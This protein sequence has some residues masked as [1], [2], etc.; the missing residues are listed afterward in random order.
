MART[1]KIS[2][3]IDFHAHI[4]MPEVQAWIRA[5]AKG[6]RKPRP[7][8]SP[9]SA[10]FQK[11]QDKVVQ[12]RS[13]DMRA[14]IRDMD[15]VG[16]DIQV[17]SAHLTHFCYW[18]PARKGLEVARMFND[19]A[20]EIVAAHPSRFVAL[21][22]VPLQ[23]PKLAVRELDRAIG[24]GARGVQISSRTEEK[25][26]GDPAHEPFWEAAEAS[27]LPVYIHPHGFTNTERM[28]EYFLWNSIAQPLEEA[29][30]M[31]SIIYSGLLDRYPRLKIV[32]AHGG[33]FLPYYAGR[34]DRA[35]DV[36][37]ETRANINRKPSAYMRK[38]YYDTCVYNADMVQFLAGKVGVG[39]IV[40]GSDY[41]VFLKEPDPVAFVQKVRGLKAADRRRITGGTAARLLKL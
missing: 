10:A 25:E 36:R 39:Q 18:A 23:A 41:P 40:M 31:S 2:K 5:N 27:G 14:R 37:T 20:A 15:K 11:R 26:L 1:P 33:G 21:A 7:R 4:N 19:R 8:V 32:M 3:V 30:A 28:G 17:I 22:A 24:L 9:S 13:T 34:V 38:F 16:I 29:M 6:P 12:S 35:Y